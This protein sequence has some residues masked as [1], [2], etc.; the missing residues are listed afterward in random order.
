MARVQRTCWDADGE[1]DYHSGESGY[2]KTPDGRVFVDAC[3]M[4]L[5][6]PLTRQL[7]LERNGYLKPSQTDIP[8]SVEVRL[9]K[10]WGESADQ[11]V[12]ETYIP[13]NVRFNQ[14]F[15]RRSSSIKLLKN[16]PEFRG[17]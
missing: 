4:D 3:R 6:K 11:S 16:P 13:R 8:I 1:G 15:L 12:S 7:P 10:S 9:C 14:A 2:R 17:A 5:R